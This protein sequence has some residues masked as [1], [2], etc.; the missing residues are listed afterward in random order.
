[1]TKE[2]ISS[3]QTSLV[4]SSDESQN[5]ET[6]NYFQIKHFDPRLNKYIYVKDKSGQEVIFEEKL[7]NPLLKAFFPE[8][9]DQFSFAE[10]DNKTKV[11]ELKNHPDGHVLLLS[12]KKRM[13]Y[14]PRE[15]LERINQLCPDPKDRG[16][17]GSIFLGDC[18]QQ[19]TR[20]L[21][22]LVVD[23][24][25]GENGG[26]LDPQ[27]ARKLVG[28]CHGKMTPAIA[29]ELSK[30]GKTDR[31]I[32]H[33]LGFT[34]NNDPSD[35]LRFGKGTLVPKD[36][37][38]LPYL[39]DTQPIDL[40]VPKSSFKG[41]DPLN[42]PIALGV[43][44]VDVWLGNKEES[45]KTK[46]ALSQIHASFPNGI[47]DYAEIL[48]KQAENLAEI[49]QDPRRL[50]QYYCAKYE[51]HQANQTNQK[52]Q[53]N[54]P[55]PNN[56][57]DETA[58]IGKFTHNSELVYQLLKQ[59]L[60][61]GHPQ[62][63]ETPIIINELKSF[64]RREKVEIAIGKSICFER[65]MIIPS[66]NLKNGEIFVPWLD[67]GED[68][69]NFRSPL[70]NSNGMCVSRNKELPEEL[71][72]SG[73]Y[74]SGVIF[75][76]DETHQEIVQRINAEIRQLVA[77][78]NEKSGQKIVLT[79]ADFL[80]ETIDYDG[81]SGKKLVER[82]AQQNAQ[83]ETIASRLGIDISERIPIETESQR[84]GR[85]F[86]GDCIGVALAS[87]F[88][89]LAAEVIRRNLPENAYIPT[90]KQ[91]KQ[92]FVDIETEGDRTIEVPWLFERIALFMSNS[93]QIIGQ[94][95][96]HL[97]AVEALESEL[98]IISNFGSKNDRLELIHKLSQR[99]SDLVEQENKQQI[100]IIPEHY[101]APMKAIADISSELSKN[102]N[103][104]DSLI[105]EALSTQKEIYRQMNAEAAFENQ[106]GVDMFK[107]AL[108]ANLALIQR[109]KQLLYRTP[110]YITEKKNTQ[111]YQNNTTLNSEGFSPV[112]ILIAQANQIFRDS[113]LSARPIEQFADL[114]PASYTPEQYNKTLWSKA[115]FDR[116]Y[117]E[118][119]ALNEKSQ[120]EDGPVIKF[121][122]ADGE[123]LEITNLTQFDHPNAYE[124][125]FLSRKDCQLRLYSYDNGKHHHKLVVTAPVYDKNGKIVKEDGKVVDQRLGTLCE[126]ARQKSQ[127]PPDAMGTKLTA[128]TASIERVN[129]AIIKEKF[130]DAKL[131]ARSFREAIP[132]AE[133]NAMAAAAWVACHRGKNL[134]SNKFVYEAFGDII[135]DRLKELHLDRVTIGRL[136]NSE[137][138]VIDLIEREFPFEVTTIHREQGTANREQNIGTTIP[139]S[140]FPIPSSATADDN[141]LAV[142][143]LFDRKLGTISSQNAQLPIGSSGVAKIVSNGTATATAAIDDGQG[144]AIG[145]T[146][147]KMKESAFA[148]NYFANEKVQIEFVKITPKKPIIYFNGEELGELDDSSVS[149]LQE[150]GIYQD[151]LSLTNCTLI[152]RGSKQGTFVLIQG[153]SGKVLR[154]NCKSNYDKVPRFDNYSPNTPIQLKF[155]PQRPQIA[156]KLT[157]NGK[158]AIAGYL[159]QKKQINAFNNSSLQLNTTYT[160]SLQSNLTNVQA[161]ID[162]IQ[163]PEL[164][165]FTP[166]P[167]L[168]D[169]K[170]SQSPDRTPTAVND[171][172]V[173]LNDKLQSLSDLLSRQ[174]TL[175]FEDDGSLGIAID[176][177]SADALDR[178]L[179]HN[180]V[181]YQLLSYEDPTVALENER[182]YALFLID[183]DTM[184]PHLLTK[185]GDPISGRENYRKALS[186]QLTI[187]QKKDPERLKN[188]GPA[189]NRLRAIEENSLAQILALEIIKKTHERKG[190]N[191]TAAIYA[192]AHQKALQDFSNKYGSRAEEF[193]TKYDASSKEYLEKNRIRIPQIA[194]DFLRQEKY[195]ENSE[196]TPLLQAALNNSPVP[197]KLQPA[198][199]SIAVENYL[200]EGKGGKQ[201]AAIHQ[202]WK[203]I[204]QN[205]L[206]AAAQKYL[207]YN[208]HISDILVQEFLEKINQVLSSN[209]APDAPPLAPTTVAAH[210]PNPAPTI[211]DNSSPTIEK[212]TS[213]TNG[214]VNPK[215]IL[216]NQQATVKSSQSTNSEINA[217][218]ST[219]S[220]QTTPN[221]FQSQVKPQTQTQPSSG[222]PN[223]QK[224]LI[225]NNST[226]NGFS[227]N[228][229]PKLKP[230]GNKRPSLPPAKSA[231]NSSPK[232]VNPTTI[233]QQHSSKNQPR[234]VLTTLETPSEENKN[235][236]PSN[237]T[238]SKDNPP[239][240]T[241][242]ELPPLSPK[243]M[244]VNIKKQ[245]ART[246]I[247]ADVLSGLMNAEDSIS[248]TIG[249]QTGT[250]DGKQLKLIDNET[251]K[252]KMIA[253]LEG[254]QWVGKPLGYD[255][256]GLTG[257]DTEAFKLMTPLVKQKLFEKRIRN[258]KKC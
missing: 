161:V 216:K 101:R 201:R 65:A 243:F 146:F 123:E 80:D 60:E 124:A 211:I 155:K 133:V 232:P 14:G 115:S 48:R 13:L 199:T 164:G 151:N 70:I 26:F 3:T 188:A 183:K 25:N 108:A 148:N 235:N 72:P 223:P 109:N 141:N 135:I 252:I 5:S 147:G 213:S 94:I 84:Q 212:P 117:N 59:Q 163:Y 81:L 178:T 218:K 154:L 22:I 210:T 54:N 208:P 168:I 254:E 215:S 150:A 119:T 21:R 120:H 88:P 166:I 112:E 95:S 246:K 200:K 162:R 214:S 187:A 241:Q 45:K 52:E 157:A 127:Y 47:R 191:A 78:K 121:T 132:E 253:S 244:P 1:M 158:E 82:V 249:P 49:E 77:A 24:E 32:Q 234:E 219:Q 126:I 118:A 8:Y 192:L 111:I 248:L 37:S 38:D 255:D 67:N 42:N 76:S 226:T 113:Q 98:E 4:S 116:L 145:I 27:E 92:S 220:T 58:E 55:D 245:L 31:V 103:P 125:D 227:P 97:T 236:R 237:A 171:A 79:D 198:V 56:N 6:K 106:V 225:A 250:W 170:N 43:H 196:Y 160:A 91:E 100:I 34:A 30:D 28:D 251:Q 83:L 11:E 39:K 203:Q 66:K 144:R 104:P 175:V 137:F 9:L 190:D 129:Q 149:I 69:I 177:Q 12:S 23:D 75:V 96:N 217:V 195:L 85:D 205:E 185:F 257:S 18:Q 41:G 156:V 99:Y 51:E 194:R 35:Q 152:T 74:P 138:N 239:Q 44:E 36:L 50:A 10:V 209:T 114:F 159:T 102:D 167:V 16:A 153:K 122:T 184:P 174:P 182:G 206:R 169:Q 89:N 258:S 222:S 180:Q 186:K 242:I 179:N 189:R 73:E 19:I 131:I 228:M 143:Q 134:S 204:N 17:Y 46:N 238:I 57:P 33:R 172:E 247:V 128:Q 68:I 64:V 230:K 15:C 193:K 136:S 110:S 93:S 197:D 40:I 229:K 181:Q 140:P 139:H 53:P 107:S 87:L 240:K 61:S 221:N 173:K 62:I 142:L 165:D 29:A 20:K 202:Q 176:T 86:D 207:K 7:E 256:P 233:Q 231:N 2:V 224:T 63:L 71:L 105:N 130:N 90:I